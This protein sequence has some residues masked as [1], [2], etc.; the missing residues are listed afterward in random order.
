MICLLESYT[1][2]A[3]VHLSKDEEESWDKVLEVM[4]LMNRIARSLVKMF[5]LGDNN[6]DSQKER[7]TKSVIT[8]DTSPSILSYLWKT[9][10]LH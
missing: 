9:Q 7:I 6:S 8:K 1:K 5:I 3:Q 10:E 2:G 4:N